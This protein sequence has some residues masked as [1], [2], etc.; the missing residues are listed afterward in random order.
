MLEHIT[1]KGQ[2]GTGVIFKSSRPAAEETF[3]YSLD[4]IED[5]QG[6]LSQLFGIQHEELFTVNDLYRFISLTSGESELPN[7]LVNK[8]LYIGN[9][10][11]QKTCLQRR[12]FCT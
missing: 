7:D 6:I 5:N 1:T 2:K 12:N 9:F 3:M 8:I 10:D 4:E 11:V